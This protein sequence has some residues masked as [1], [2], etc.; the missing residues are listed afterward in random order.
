MMRGHRLNWSKENASLEY[1]IK[2]HLPDYDVEYDRNEQ[3]YTPI[4]IRAKNDR[5]IIFTMDSGH[6]NTVFTRSKDIV[7]IAEFSYAATGCSV[8]AIDLKSRKPVWK[9]QLEG[10]GPT[11]HTEYVN[12]VNIETDGKRIVV[13][14]NEGNGRYVEVLDI[15]T[16][17]TLANKKLEPDIE[18]L[19]R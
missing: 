18:S 2:K 10:I 19:T 7:Y 1:C 5:K 9:T 15:K 14:G 4:K 12:L 17:K 11:D 13:N 16:G 6:L 8:V 3:F